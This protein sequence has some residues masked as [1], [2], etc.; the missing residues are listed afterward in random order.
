MVDAGFY[1][2]GTNEHEDRV[3]C[4]SCGIENYDWKLNSSDP[5]LEHEK[6]NPNCFYLELKQKPKTDLNLSDFLLI[7][8]QRFKQRNV[9][10]IN[11]TFGLIN[12]INLIIHKDREL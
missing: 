4:Y 3:I 9:S 2:A 7:E 6:L 1:F 10:D 5:W 11:L 12:L 8:K